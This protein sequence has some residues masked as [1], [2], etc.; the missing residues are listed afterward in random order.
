M[1]GPHAWPAVMK[2]EAARGVL[3]STVEFGGGEAIS[4]AVFLIL[5]R[6]VTPA[7]FGA[8]ALAGIVVT[9]LQLFLGQ[10][11][12]DAMIQ[13]EEASP[14]Q[15]STAFWTNLI[16]ALALILLILA[17]AGGCAA[18]LGHRGLAPVLRG[19]SPVLLTA[20]FISIH[21]AVF[22]RR[23]QFASLALRALIAITAGGTVGIAAALA[24]WGVWSLVA[25]QVTN[26]IV[27]VVVLWWRCPWHPRLV[28][29]LPALREM[30]PF[31]AAVIGSAVAGFLVRRCDLFLIGLF[32]PTREV[33][34]Y[35]LVQRILLTLGLVTLSTV[36]SIVMPVLSRLQREPARFREVFVLMIEVVHAIWLPVAL[37][38]ALVAGR[39]VPMLFG[40]K[41]APAAP[42]LA[43]YGAVG[44]FQV[45]SQFT[46][47]ALSAAGRPEAN[48]KLVVIQIAA[49]LAVMLPAVRLGLEAVAAARV[50]ATFLIVAPHLWVLRRDA[51]IAPGPLLYRTRV[52]TFA[53][54]VM[55]MALI[56]LQLGPLAG[57]HGPLPLALLIGI[58]ALLYTA[59]IALLAPQAL[60]RVAAI[61][62]GAFRGEATAGGLG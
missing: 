57:L 3:W 4:F 19:L 31:G 33:G 43:I 9:F 59:I 18:L 7:D 47:S 25:Q 54:I 60:R 16:L 27:S 41:W 62:G 61:L 49:T 56:G 51:G 46:G 20:A 38:A 28:F 39:A 32:L 29:S 24:G 22:K 48:L 45:F 14:E 12:A 42:V 8:V 11:L 55:A 23:L 1:A 36:Q 17:T 2:F 26:G 50:L 37:G 5:A 13:R 52:S 34:Y 53:G 44:F 10:G 6:L 30:L 40:A 15:L 58:G 21:Q 35:V